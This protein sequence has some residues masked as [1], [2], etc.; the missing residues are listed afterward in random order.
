[1]L[2]STGTAA[3]WGQLLPTLTS[4]RSLPALR[5]PQPLLPLCRSHVRLPTH[6]LKYSLCAQHSVPRVLHPP[7]EED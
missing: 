2:S 4:P 6:F 3:L 1:M 7:A 5:G